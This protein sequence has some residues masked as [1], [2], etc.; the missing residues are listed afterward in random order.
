LIDEAVIRYALERNAAEDPHGAFISFEGGPAWTREQAVIEMYRAANALRAAGVRRDDHVALFLPNGEDYIRAW[1]AV[2]CLGAVVVPLNTSY[3]GE[4]LRHALDLA[5]CDVIVIEE[6]F[7]ERLNLIDTSTR[8]VST[9]ELL[10]DSAES[11]KLER[12][13]EVWDLHAILL[14]SGTTG[15]PKAS[16]TSYLH[17][18]LNSQGF[19]GNIGLDATDTY[20]V[21]LPLFHVAAKAQVAAC[22]G[23]RTKLAIRK[24]PDLNRYWE[25]AKE[26]GATSAM[27]FSSMAPFL[28]SK[29][30]QASDSDHSLRI[31]CMSP[32]P[33]DPKAFMARFGIEHIMSAYGATE[34]G[35]PLT[36]SLDEPVVP[37][38]MGRPRPG[39]QVRLVDEHDMEVPDGEP[40]EFIM[41]T[42]HPWEVT[43]GYFNNP[44]ATAQMW[45]NG[46]L[47]TGDLIRRD[48][49]GLYFFHDRK[50]DCVRRR[51]ENVSSFEV[52]RDVKFYPGVA[53]VACVAVPSEGGDEEVKVW[54]VPEADVSLEFGAMLEFLVDRM[55]HFMVPRYF[56]L[57][58]ALPTN[59]SMRIQKH[60]LRSLG[61]GPSTWDREQHRYSVTRNGLVKREEAFDG[62]QG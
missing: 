21:D 57:I 35:G 13:L 41:R 47:H 54:I 59:S 1:W 22:L 3:R 28:M 53:E 37:G 43:M 50:K 58:D 18:Y 38:S 56:E 32:P 20:L 2:C 24:R 34:C 30:E 29:P 17:I 12:D 14:T 62:S 31:I 7:R 10:G 6:S 9:V 15:P 49:S 51:G 23:T 46:W 42:D 61:N 16:L 40:G 25:V 36:T 39:V 4:S 48:D 5:Q 55:P 19:I 26:T 11:P 60:E 8:S 33:I 44:E 45:R 52:E 27:L